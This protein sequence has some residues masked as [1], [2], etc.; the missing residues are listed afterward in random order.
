MAE[1]KENS[2]CGCYIAIAVI[3]FTILLAQF[4]STFAK[5]MEVLISIFTF[6][7]IIV[8]IVMLIITRK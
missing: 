4:N 1:E 6:L 2:G 5:G 7:F 8:S 3:I